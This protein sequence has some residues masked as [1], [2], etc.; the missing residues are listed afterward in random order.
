MSGV[1]LDSNV[2]LYLLSADA[3]KADTAEKLIAQQ[4]TI[5]VQVLNEVTSVCLRKL[6]LQWPETLDLLNAIKANCKVVPLTLD[7]HSKALEV[8]QQHRLSFYDAHIVAA[9][10]DSGAH[11]LMSEDMHHGATIQGLRIQNPF[12][13]PGTRLT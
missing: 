8:A 1:F 2:I 5:S 10:I 9:A 13:H 6:Q 3:V 7:T 12:T 4:P 11:T